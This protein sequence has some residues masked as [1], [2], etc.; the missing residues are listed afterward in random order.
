MQTLAIIY[1]LF[2]G[3]LIGKSFVAECKRRG[4]TIIADASKADVIVAHSG[5]WMF[6]PVNNAAKQIILIDAAHKSSRSLISKF[7]ARVAYDVR[8]I[9]FSKL[10]IV[11]L[12]Q[13]VLNV[14]Y[15]VARFPT[16]LRMG[17]RYNTYDIVPLIKQSNVVVIQSDDLSWYDA[18]TMMYAYHFFQ[19]DEGCHDDCWIHPSVHMSVSVTK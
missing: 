11:W 17:R 19:L 3:P 2:E 16:W 15:F 1:G 14:W 8:H 10:F 12:V 9:V 13:R 5:G 7:A 18:E 6:L 4:Y